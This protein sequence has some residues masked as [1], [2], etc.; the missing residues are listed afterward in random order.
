[1]DMFAPGVPQVSRF[2]TFSIGYKKPDPVIFFKI[3]IQKTAKFIKKHA[4]GDRMA[5]SSCVHLRSRS[6]FRVFY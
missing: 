4:F 5:L 6:G 1:M 3:Q 2:F